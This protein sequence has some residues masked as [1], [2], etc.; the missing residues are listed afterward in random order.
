VALVKDRTARRLIVGGLAVA[1]AI[2]LLGPSP[3]QPAQ[4]RPT[5]G[6]EIVAVLV[7]S[8]TCAGIRDPDMKAAWKSIKDFLGRRAESQEQSFVTVGLALDQDVEL[9]ADAIGEFGSF[10]ELHLGRSFLNAAAVRYL[11]EL[12]GS[13][14]LPQVVI[15]ERQVEV[16]GGLMWVRSERVISRKVGPEAIVRWARAAERQEGSGVTGGAGE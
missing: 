6:A 8:S 3:S 13:W 16:K 4:D 2:L 7:V 11:N 14:G 1:G 5:S 15:F 12:Y 10:D 9:G